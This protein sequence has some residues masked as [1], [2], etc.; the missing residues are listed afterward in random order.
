MLSVFGDD[1]TDEKKERVF[2]VAGV[3]GTQE[4]WDG[5]E[6]RW[7]KRLRHTGVKIF[8]ATDCESGWGEYENV[9]H[10]ERTKL[11]KDLTKMLAESEMFGYGVA[12]DLNGFK[13]YMYDAEENDPYYFA[14]VA[15]ALHFVSLV[16]L[17]IHKQQ[18]EFVFD[19]NDCVR[20]NSALLY[21]HFLT[22]RPEY[23]Q[24][25]SY[26]KEKIGYETSRAVGIQVADLFTF[27]TMKDLDNR[28]GPVRRP[29]RI[30]LEKLRDTK[31]FKIDCF[32][33]RNYF[34]DFRA[35]NEQQLQA[36]SEDYEQWRTKH[37]Y[38]HTTQ[39]KFRYCIYRDSI[40][41]L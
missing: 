19:I 4:Q 40:R 29:T 1:S 18:V 32:T 34:R 28:I 8:H 7:L 33:E 41:K 16:R 9:S 26:M 30:S 23:S 11:Y 24:Y 27:E 37:G 20:H 6:R 3:A 17:I 35:R 10:K 25:T 31:R 5:F 22:Q 13:K 12:I 36:E 2:A 38:P 21:E 39:I 14:F 15:V